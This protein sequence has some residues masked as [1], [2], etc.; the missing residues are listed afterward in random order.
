MPGRCFF[1]SGALL[2]QITRENKAKLAQLGYSKDAIS[3]LQPAVA[4][5]VLEEGVV[6]AD[7]DDWLAATAGSD[8]AVDAE[9]GA[10]ELVDT[11]GPPPRAEAA[12]AVA[13]P[14]ADDADSDAATD[15]DA[16]KADA[17]K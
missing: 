5:A 14:A 4:M 15:A 6:A 2:R 7:F 16:A 12:L 3:H 17:P 10:D 9:V 13:P 8:E 11:T 1:T